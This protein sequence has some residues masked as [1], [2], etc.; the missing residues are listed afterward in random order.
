MVVK[1]LLEEIKMK[2]THYDYMTE[3]EALDYI[4]QD[5]RIISNAAWNEGD[6]RIINKNGTLVYVKDGE[7]KEIKPSF[8]LNQD[9]KF[10]FKGKIELDSPDETV[11][12]PV[13]K[14]AQLL[15]EVKDLKNELNHLYH[16]LEE[17]GVL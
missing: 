3:K 8:L 14:F 2:L 15:G 17:R 13:M 16:L 9:N 10:W 6:T 1:T 11:Q 4:T 5:G 7:R 12:V